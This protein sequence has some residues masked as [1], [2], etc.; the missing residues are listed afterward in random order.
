[1]L[2][3]PQHSACLPGEPTEHAR[4]NPED[5][6]LLIWGT[7]GGCPLARLTL[8]PEC[9]ELLRG[10]RWVLGHTHVAGGVSHFRRGNLGVHVASPMA[11]GPP[12]TARAPS[13]P[14]Q[15][16]PAPGGAPSE[17]HLCLHGAM[18]R[19]VTP[20]PARAFCDIR[21]CEADR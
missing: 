1:M 7:R 19:E 10:A 18:L 12:G 17:D 21:G 9:E 5:Q 13:H 2:E 3:G 6:P 14:S 16:R 15:A 20:R 8:H 11:L 4:A